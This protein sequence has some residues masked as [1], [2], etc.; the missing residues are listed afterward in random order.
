[1]L[2][3]LVQEDNLSHIA[4]TNAPPPSVR[5][6]G[7]SAAPAVIQHQPIQ[8]V[9]EEKVIAH[10]TRDGAV[11]AFEVKGSLT[12]T[13][14]TEAAA[15][16]KVQLA[17]AD[18]ASVPGLNFQTHPKVNKA[19]YDQNKVLMLKDASKGFPV[20]RPV[21]VLR[22]SLS[23]T[24]DSMVPLSINCWPEEEGQ[25]K[26]NISIEYQMNGVN[27]ELHDVNISIPLG[28]VEVPQVASIDGNYRHDPREQRLVWH[29]DLIDTANASGALEFIVAGRDPSAF[30]PIVVSFASQTL[31]A[32]IKVQAVTGLEEE[33]PPPIPYSMS[34][35]LSPDSY[36]IG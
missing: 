27:R 10:L 7:D 2:D 13:A 4:T 29:M 8:L 17:M 14:T 6:G 34:K 25:G 26:M 16:S 24:E 23:S 28:T 1:M 35:S 31:Y 12:L 21:G 20:G 5:G 11:D 32:D 30:F 3:S 18:P 19:L 22:W 15:L 9:I 36:V 33:N